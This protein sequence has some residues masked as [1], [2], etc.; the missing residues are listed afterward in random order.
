MT[1]HV[2]ALDRVFHALSDPTRRAIVAQL[3][4]GP[5]SVSELSQPFTIAMPTLLAH[6]R[7]LEDSGLIASEK[8]GRVRTCTIRPAILAATSAWLDRQC[9][10]WESRLDRM[11]A[12][13]AEL[14][15]KDRKHGKRKR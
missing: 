10:V 13:V 2:T 5:A 8:T 3:A 11:E 9:A 12:Y 6:L 4:Q 15:A 1:N 7:V 14:H